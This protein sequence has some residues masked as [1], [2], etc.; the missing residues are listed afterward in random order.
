MSLINNDNKN[1]VLNEGSEVKIGSKVKLTF[2]PFF[3]GKL[4][5]SDSEDDNEFGDPREFATS[6]A[7]NKIAED[8]LN[9]I[10]TS[11]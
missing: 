7:V 6:V 10:M 4:S 5:I 2:I 9:E 11:W 8:V 3:D 1:Q